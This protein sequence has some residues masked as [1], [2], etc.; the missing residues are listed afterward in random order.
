METGF[1]LNSL[2]HGLAGGRVQICHQMHQFSTTIHLLPIA[3]DIVRVNAHLEGKCV[4]LHPVG[5]YF[6]KDQRKMVIKDIIFKILIHVLLQDQHLWPSP[7]HSASVIQSE[8]AALSKRQQVL[9][10]IRN[11][12]L[13]L[14]FELY[15][16]NSGSQ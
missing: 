16:L 4:T 2:H 1:I 14:L 9:S 11:S 13:C 3:G 5:S 15:F 12:I 6:I 8:Q 7:S 10:P